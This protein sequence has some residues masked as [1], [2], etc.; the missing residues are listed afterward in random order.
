MGW[1]AGTFGEL[2][3]HSVTRR[4]GLASI[5]LSFLQ[6]FTHFCLTTNKRNEFGKGRIKFLR[7][8]CLFRGSKQQQA[9]VKPPAAGER[10]SQQQAPASSYEQEHPATSEKPR[11]TSR[12]SSSYPSA[13]SLSLLFS[14]PSI[15]QQLSARVSH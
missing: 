10:S 12:R 9:T 4:V 6:F 8:S 1:R 5:R 14:S 7:V 13:A 2:K 3:R 11:T 15:L